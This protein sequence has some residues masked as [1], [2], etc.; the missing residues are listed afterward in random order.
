MN[1]QTLGGLYEKLLEPPQEQLERG[2]VH[3]GDY[4]L[5]W[6]PPGWEEKLVTAGYKLA[7]QGK[8]VQES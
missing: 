1:E 3:R 2:Q 4:L 6:E 7:L 8:K 5:N